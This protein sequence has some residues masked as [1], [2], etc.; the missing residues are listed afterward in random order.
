MWDLWSLL[1]C[2][3][4]G[5]YLDHSVVV[6]PE[7]NDE[8]TE[9]FLICRKCRAVF[10]VWQG[11]PI[12]CD[13]KRRN[14]PWEFELF[15]ALLGRISVPNNHESAV[16]SELQHL[17]CSKHDQI[18]EWEDVEYWDGV[19][20][21]RYETALEGHYHG[22]DWEYR[23]SQRTPLLHFMQS[24]LSNNFVIEVGCGESQNVRHLLTRST[25]TRYL[26]VDMSFHAL[27]LSRRLLD[28]TDARFIL[29]PADNVPIRRGTAGMLLCFGVMHHCRGK[30][31]TLKSLMPLLRTG[32]Y[33]VLDEALERRVFRPK[34]LSRKKV[35]YHE[36]RID[37]VVLHDLAAQLGT[38]LFWREFYT[39]FFGFLI[40]IFPG[41][42]FLSKHTRLLQV[43]IDIDHRI[44][45]TLHDFSSIFQS[46]QCM[47]V[48]R[49]FK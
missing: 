43:L 47:S 30:E 35:S 20:Q 44:A 41:H 33:L 28:S 49:K 27:L 15:S 12:I 6:N 34:L 16:H 21:E 29:C 40:R 3:D 4:C 7:T 39:A 5:S 14:K 19:Y 11:I 9:G 36:E 25:R 10:A 24:H 22:G 8:T 45:S 32:G 46:G 13:R 1:L 2:P 37:G 23:L 42:V 48:L 17:A 31:Q 18:W 26:A 38:I